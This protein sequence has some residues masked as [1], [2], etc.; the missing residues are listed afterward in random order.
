MPDIYNPDGNLI[1]K[2]PAETALPIFTVV[3]AL[4]AKVLGVED[5]DTILYIGLVLSFVP[6]AITWIVNMVRGSKKPDTATLRPPTTVKKT[7]P[8]G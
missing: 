4:I 8:K 5:T 1:Q 3:A 6:A 7:T 2:H